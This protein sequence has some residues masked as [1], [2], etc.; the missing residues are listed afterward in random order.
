MG[1]RLTG[2]IRPGLVFSVFCLIVYILFARNERI[3]LL[4]AEFTPSN[5]DASHPRRIDYDNL[6]LDEAECARTFPGLAKEVDNFVSQ[7]PFDLPF[8]PGVV[9]Q[10]KIENNNVSP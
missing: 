7:G 4:D 1:K 6:F 8:R 5:H 9:L 3:S 10:G 2:R